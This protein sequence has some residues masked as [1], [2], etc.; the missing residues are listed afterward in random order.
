MHATLADSLEHLHGLLFNMA[1]VGG[2]Q[3]AFTQ[4]QAHGGSA[5]AA[6]I[7]SVLISSA[8]AQGA[9][10]SLYCATAPGIEPSAGAYFSNCKV[11][12]PKASAEDMTMAEKLWQLSEKLTG[13]SYGA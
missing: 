8:T 6:S 5:A 1:P 13:T 2:G 4:R 10:T 11:T 12:S 9:A 7:R 3:S